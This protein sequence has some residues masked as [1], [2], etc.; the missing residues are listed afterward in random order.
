M[1][2]ARRTARSRATTTIPGCRSACARMPR[3]QPLRRARDGHEPCRRAGGADAPRP[4]A[5]RHRH[6]HRARPPGLLRRARKPSPM[7]R[8]RSSQGLEPGGVAIILSTARTATGCVDAAQAL[9]RRSDRHFRHQ[10]RG[11]DCP[12]AG[13]GAAGRTGARFVTRPPRPSAMLGFTLPQPGAHLG[14]QR[15]GDHRGGATPWAAIWRPGGPRARRAG[16]LAGRGDRAHR[17]RS[18]AARRW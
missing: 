2:R 8:A 13:S 9:M 18:E 16:G 6:D 5:C 12:G 14:V 17:A 3:G 4:S 10:P 15:D 1:R 11:A 7:P